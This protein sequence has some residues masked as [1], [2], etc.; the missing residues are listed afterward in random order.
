MQL[1]REAFLENLRASVYGQVWKGQATD[2]HQAVDAAED[3]P[4]PCAD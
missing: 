2:A 1:S 4:E 3:E